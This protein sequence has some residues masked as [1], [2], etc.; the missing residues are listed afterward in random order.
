[1]QYDDLFLRIQS[2]DG[3]DCRVSAR[4]SAGDEVQGR[5]RL[6][7][8]WIELE[9]RLGE[10]E[11]L[12]R[13][14]KW[15]KAGQRDSASRDVAVPT[16]PTDLNGFSPQRLGA[17]LF[18]ALFRGSIR[19]QYDRSV[20]RIS[21]KPDRGLRLW[22]YFD[23]D[24]P[25]LT[26]LCRLPWELLY[27]PEEGQ[28]EEPQFLALRRVRPVLRQLPV[29]RPL[30]LPA[31]R[32]PLRV[33]A[34]VPEPNEVAPLKLDLEIAALKQVF[35]GLGAHAK[36]CVLRGDQV[37][38]QSVH[39]TLLAEKIQVL[40][41]IG[42][43]KPDR[44]QWGLAL[45]QRSTGSL[46]VVCGER[47]ARLFQDLPDLRLLILNACSTGQVAASDAGAPVGIATTLML[48]GIPAVVA[49]QFRITD[50]AA[51]VF[52][53]R[54][55]EQLV[56]VDRETML[57]GVE[58]A[59]AE[60]RLAVAE[61]NPAAWEWV[62]PVMYARSSDLFAPPRVE[63]EEPGASP[64]PDGPL[65]PLA[66]IGLYVCCASLQAVGWLGF[67]RCCSPSMSA[68]QRVSCGKRQSARPSSHRSRSQS[69]STP[70]SLP[71]NI[72][73]AGSLPPDACSSP[74]SA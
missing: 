51:I 48:A 46:D 25:A 58:T 4:S 41:F 32:S 42:H 10:L 2:T 43:G 39:E 63:D 35:A 31:W 6:P 15:P 8:E 22:L 5:F 1:M 64:R 11:T 40:H 71:C 18:E 38:A 27:D 30:V 74:C 3:E 26:R 21:D 16:T 65:T 9:H 20:G 44:G 73:C 17:S 28:L 56:H 57:A 36:L 50:R 12:V 49:M 62:T 24:G 14:E 61:H 52:S 7:A 54:F 66:R 59:L 13:G 33:L 69:V 19:Q 45:C 37:T 29:S 23:A 68:S 70:V 67:S 55:Y 47:L 34:V 53:R 60:A 72:G